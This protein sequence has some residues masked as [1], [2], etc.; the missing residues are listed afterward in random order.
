[1]NNKTKTMYV[2]LP[3][4]FGTG[5]QLLSVYEFEDN[6]ER[7]ANTDVLAEFEPEDAAQT[8]NKNN[9]WTHTV[10]RLPEALSRWIWQPLT[11]QVHRFGKAA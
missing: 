4:G 1:M 7:A 6:L 10:A 11:R 5:A 8:P 3:G 2:M 9:R